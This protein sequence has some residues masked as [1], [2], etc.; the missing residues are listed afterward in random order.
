VFQ[1]RKK[2][3]E[4]DKMLVTNVSWETRKGDFV[5]MGLVP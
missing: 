4:E 3:P 2:I 5:V 1:K